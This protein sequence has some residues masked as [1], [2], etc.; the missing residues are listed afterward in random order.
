MPFAQQL[1]EHR[2]GQPARTGARQRQRL[3]LAHPDIVGELRQSF[4][5]RVV[6][7]QRRA[8]LQHRIGVA[9]NLFR[10]N[11][12]HSGRFALAYKAIA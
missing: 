2:V 5:E 10:R 1:L 11:P 3:Q 6:G 8:G 12:R 7:A 4:G 9:G